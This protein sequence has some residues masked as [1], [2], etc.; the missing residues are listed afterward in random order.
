M[1]LEARS[2]FSGSAMHRRRHEMTQYNWRLRPLVVQEPESP[3]SHDAVVSR[4][5]AVF[6]CIQLHVRCSGFRRIMSNVE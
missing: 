6:S 2:L 4:A 1:Q 3:N 5:D